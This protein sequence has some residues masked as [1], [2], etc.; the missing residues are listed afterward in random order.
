MTPVYRTRKKE[1]RERKKK[2]V[3][4]IV[5]SVMGDYSPFRCFLTE[6]KDDSVR[7]V[8]TQNESV[9]T[10][11]EMSVRLYKYIVCNLPRCL[12]TAVFFSF[13]VGM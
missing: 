2:K 9:V 3:N 6:Q 1:K 5:S 11:F 10:V 4:E 13:R 8:L 7:Y 12:Q